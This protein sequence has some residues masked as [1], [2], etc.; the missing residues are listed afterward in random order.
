MSILEE[1]EARLSRL[2][3]FLLERDL[4]E[5]WGSVSPFLEASMAKRI[6]SRS[7]QKLVKLQTR[8]DSRIAH[9]D[10]NTCEIAIVQNWNVFLIGSVVCGIVLLAVYSNVLKAPF[11]FDDHSSIEE[12]PSIRSIFPLSQSMWSP[13]DFSVAGRPMVSL[14]FALNYA[15]GGLN[16]FGYHLVNILIHAW[17]AS[18]VASLLYTVLRYSLDRSLPAQ[19]LSSNQNLSTVY[20]PIQESVSAGAK[21]VSNA[22]NEYAYL[23]WFLAL[24]WALHPLQS[25]TVAYVM[26]RTELMMAWALLVTLY[27]SI[28]A[29][30]ASTGATR[31][32]WQVSA[33]LAC[34]FGMLCKE[35]M[36]VAP[37]LVV[38][39]DWSFHDR[40]LKKLI[41][42]RTWLYLGLFACWGILAAIMMTDPRGRSV[43]FSLGY[44][45][46]DYMTTQCWAITKYLSLSFF[47]VGLC[48]DY[49]VF[50][51][52]DPRIWLPCFALLTSLVLTTLWM[53]FRDR[54]LAFWG[55]WFFAILAPTSSFVPIATE[56]MAER[57]MYLPLISIVVL[58][59]IG[60]VR[61]WNW[62]ASGSQNSEQALVKTHQPNPRSETERSNL[63][64]V[65]EPSPSRSK[66]GS[67]FGPII[68][69]VTLILIVGSM[70]HSRNQ[71]YESE[72]TFWTEVKRMAPRNERALGT[73]GMIHFKAERYEEAEKE[74]LKAYE[75]EP[76]NYHTHA[77][78][79]RLRLQQHRYQEARQ[80]L[81][82]AIRAQ[83]DYREALTA[84]GT[85]L[86]EQGDPTKALSFCDRALKIN[87]NHA[88]TNY[89]R[90]LALGELGRI[91]ESVAAYQ[92]ALLEDPKM[93]DAHNN[94]GEIA[95]SQMKLPEAEK[96]FRL[97]LEVDP[98]SA[99]A[100]ANLGGLMNHRGNH[101]EA[102]TWMEKAIALDPKLADAHYN[103]AMCYET[104]GRI[105]EAEAEYRICTQLNPRDVAAWM[106][107]G[108]LMRRQG[109]NTEAKQLFN[110]ALEID[111]SF[112]PARAQLQSLP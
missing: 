2:N 32:L 79:G 75:V 112:E 34:A 101:N 82:F 51:V 24:L 5:Y 36:V 43:G 106:D 103:L 109:K 15:I 38:L 50:K 8:I 60:F 69:G 53:W 100:H 26:Q 25:E 85:L 1:A 54:R 67:L 63:A 90:G 35:V 39:F 17:N 72:L 9:Y 71:V 102:V 70:T 46:W 3:I 76:R 22:K 21:T 111:P 59:S 45:S 80:Y 40:S 30:Q 14:S 93:S 86:L 47:P 11:L 48:G 31:L 42:K 74:M 108:M 99:L 13:K 88:L 41:E 105:S 7:P 94:L 95:M 84:M 73:L 52:Q 23:A 19:R 81:E 29:W 96:H 104:L 97:A 92:K 37:V 4:L 18:L 78:L 61:I 56:P 55:L 27:S 28:R 44:S 16:V 20:S 10:G 66:L 83:P 89:I 33:I 110:K 65:S 91:D 107:L 98:R 68:V 49:G 57:R 77:I 58:L 6:K 87:P 62:I 12:N 64:S